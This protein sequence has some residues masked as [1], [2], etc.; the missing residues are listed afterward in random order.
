MKRCPNCHEPY[1][2]DDYGLPLQCCSSAMW[3]SEEL[4]ECEFGDE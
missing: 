3:K 4:Y 1:E 2:L